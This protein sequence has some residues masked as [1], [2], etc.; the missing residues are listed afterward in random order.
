[1][2]SNDTAGTTGI[3]KAAANDTGNILT[4]CS[5][6]AATA[7]ALNG[8]DIVALVT[9]KTGA[10]LLSIA[11]QQG[12][13]FNME[14]ETN[15]ASATKDDA[16]GGWTFKTHGAK[17][18]DASIDGLLSLDD[19]ASKMIAKALANDEYLCLK[20][21][22]R[23]KGTD[24][25]VKYVPIRM[26]LAIVTSDSFEAPSD[27]NAT[28]SMDFDGTGAPWLYETATDAEIEAATVTLA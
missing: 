7:S 27:D 16:S 6:D 15:E 20:I 3:T 8:K 17:S 22:Q 21:C 25:A 12:L 24:G 28:Y 2:A 11:G 19:E 18:W 5:F 13:S 23:V 1:M 10:K 4:G 26:G 9:D 14:A